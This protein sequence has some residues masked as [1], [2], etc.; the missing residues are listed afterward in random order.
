MLVIPDE[1]ALFVRGEGCL[2][3]PRKSKEEGDVGGVPLVLHTHTHIE[4]AEVCGWQY[5]VGRGVQG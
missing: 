5:D 3:R 1:E 4:E 2:A